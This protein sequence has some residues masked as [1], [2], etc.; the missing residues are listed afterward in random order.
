MSG[1]PGTTHRPPFMFFVGRAMSALACC[2]ALGWGALAFVY[3]RHELNVAQWIT[4]ACQVLTGMGCGAVFWFIAET[5]RSLAETA[6][7]SI[8]T[9]RMLRRGR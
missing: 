9:E 5:E 1:A 4:V 2:A 3:G 8:E 7:I 6:R